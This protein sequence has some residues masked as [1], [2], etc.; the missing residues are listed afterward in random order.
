MTAPEC[1]QAEQLAA[2]V[3]SELDATPPPATEQRPLLYRSHEPD[4]AAVGPCIDDF[5]GDKP[6]RCTP[7]RE[8]TVPRGD[9]DI[10]AAAAADPNVECAV[11]LEPVRAHLGE[12]MTPTTDR[13]S[14]RFLEPTHASRVEVNFSDVYVPDHYGTEADLY[15]NRK[16]IDVSGHPA[17]H[18]ESEL[19]GIRIDYHIYASPGSDTSAPGFVHTLLSLELPRGAPSG[20]PIDTT[21][22]P[23]LEK[24]MADL[25]ST[26]FD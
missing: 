1:P 14:C 13:S 21:R 20:T 8:V 5:D 11:A 3:M 18:F 9:K 12:S 16:K 10:I 25:M 7:Y 19:R 24:I 2:T 15:Q 23:L 6:G 4:T 22:A 26:H 17:I